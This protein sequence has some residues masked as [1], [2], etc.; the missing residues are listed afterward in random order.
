MER[1]LMTVEADG[2]EIETLRIM[3]EIYCSGN[4]GTPSGLCV[5]CGELLEY[6]RKRV[7]VCPH[8]PDKP[9][10]RV[11]KIHCFTLDKRDKIRR[12]MGYSGPRMALHH[13]LLAFKHLLRERK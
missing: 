4:H 7:S 10:C 8:L 5:E 9:T 13:P 2:R 6:A 1:A 11:C 3:L 12:V